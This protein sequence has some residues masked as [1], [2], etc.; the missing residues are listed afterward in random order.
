M[1]LTKGERYMLECCVAG[2]PQNTFGKGGARVQNSLRR[3]G[4]GYF[5]GGDADMPE[6]FVINA[7]GRAALSSAADESPKVSR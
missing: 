4:L 1:K 7:A 3:K 5:I 6:Q 2:G